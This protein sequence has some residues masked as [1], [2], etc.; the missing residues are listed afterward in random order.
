M[1]T[2]CTDRSVDRI[3]SVDRYLPPI[4]PPPPA[5]CWFVCYRAFGGGRYGCVY[6]PASILHYHVARGGGGR[7]FV[8]NILTFYLPLPHHPFWLMRWTLV[9]TFDDRTFLTSIPHT[10][11]ISAVAW[12]FGQDRRAWFAV[13]L[14]PPHPTLPYPP[15]F[16][17][18]RCAW[19]QH[20]RLVYLQHT[21]AP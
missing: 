7:W 5:A 14:P 13:A 15:H 18:R 16:W 11:H 6:H 17:F 12:R 20:C 10:P 4:L 9:G 8:M 1:M 19:R 3:F 21:F 2:C